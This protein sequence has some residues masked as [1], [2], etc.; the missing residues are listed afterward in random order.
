MQTWG[1]EELEVDE[2]IVGT[3][4]KP[5]SD[6]VVPPDVFCVVGRH[7]RGKKGGALLRA[8]Q[9]KDFGDK[10]VSLRKCTTNR[11]NR[12][13]TLLNCFGNSKHF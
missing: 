10:I 4:R 9:K 3:M 8:H 6:M 12:L 5:Q 2:K 1:L 11:P 13:K 7:Y